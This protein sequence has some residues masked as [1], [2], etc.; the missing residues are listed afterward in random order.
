MMFLNG[1]KKARYNLVTG[2]IIKIRNYLQTQLGITAQVVPAV[3]LAVLGQPFE[4][5]TGTFFV[6]LLLFANTKVEVISVNA[7]I[8]IMIFFIFIFF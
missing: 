6:S 7:D 4:Q 3:Q 8:P 5:V 1:H 2:F